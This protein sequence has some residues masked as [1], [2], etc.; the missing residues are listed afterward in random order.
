MKQNVESDKMWSKQQQKYDCMQCSVMA[1]SAG[2][3]GKNIAAQLAG[4]AEQ[5]IWWK[6]IENCVQLKQINNVEM[7]MYNIERNIVFY[8]YIFARFLSTSKQWNKIKEEKTNCEQWGKRHR[9]SC[10]WLNSRRNWRN[11]FAM[12]TI[13]TRCHTV[14]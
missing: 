6:N 14:G 9:R 4:F 5:I 3:Q 10:L 2:R 11:K 7:R 8:F 12:K 1:I 13:I